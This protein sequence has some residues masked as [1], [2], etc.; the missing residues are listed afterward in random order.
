MT[1]DFNYFFVL[2]AFIVNRNI[3]REFLFIN[4]MSIWLVGI[5]LV[6]TWLDFIEA[7]YFEAY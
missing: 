1:V 3:Y 7:G 6:E 5:E 2:N 4:F